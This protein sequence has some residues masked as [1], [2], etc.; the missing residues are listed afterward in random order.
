MEISL[1]DTL[2]PLEE[3]ENNKQ[4]FFL[5]GG[6]EHDFNFSIYLE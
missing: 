4:Q 6:L 5:V 1:T 3:I 2:E